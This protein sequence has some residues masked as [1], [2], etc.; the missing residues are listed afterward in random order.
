PDGAQIACGTGNG[1]LEMFARSSGK[2]D[3]GVK[4]GFG[5]VA[6]VMVSPTGTLI[7]AIAPDGSIGTWSARDGKEIRKAG[8]PVS[9]VRAIGVSS[10]GRHA[11]F[12]VDSGSAKVLEP[13][14]GRELGEVPAA[15]G[16]VTAAAVSNQG[17]FSAIGFKN[18]SVRLSIHR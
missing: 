5:P 1:R 18:A 17:R 15:A 12:G 11:I 4:T 8:P 10:D 9:G 6:R 14:T 13:E 2:P 3:W 16:I 7:L